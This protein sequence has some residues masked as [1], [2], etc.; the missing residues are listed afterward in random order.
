M[1]GYRRSVPTS[2]RSQGLV[3]AGECVKA[4]GRHSV[5]SGVYLNVF[6]QFGEEM[7]FLLS[8][9]VNGFNLYSAFIQSDLPMSVPTV[10][11]NNQHIR[12]I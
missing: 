11:G 4:H 12:S 6:S 3:V 7:A 10:Q 8:V 1:R 9:M 2:T 5:V